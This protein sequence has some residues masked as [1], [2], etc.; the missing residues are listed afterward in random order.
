MYV[1]LLIGEWGHWTSS[2]LPCTQPLCH[3]HHHNIE[4]R[5]EVR[6]LRNRSASDWLEFRGL[7]Q[8]TEY[9]HFKKA[10]PSQCSV[11]IR[12]QKWH[13]HMEND[14]VFLIQHGESICRSCSG[15]I[16][17]TLIVCIVV[18]L[19]KMIESWYCSCDPV[20]LFT[21]LPVSGHTVNAATY[22]AQGKEP[23]EVKACWNVT[24][25]RGAI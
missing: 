11:F 1:I 2:S 25:T 12:S 13:H 22:G 24:H 3:H 14:T 15:Y 8:S 10:A 23:R 9:F 4:I 16:W 20:W 19:D 5:A 18:R 21:P 6:A 7:F 17:Q